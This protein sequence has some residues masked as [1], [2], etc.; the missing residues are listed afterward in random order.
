MFANYHPASVYRTMLPQFHVGEIVDHKVS[1]FVKEHRSIRQELLRRGMFET[2]YAFY[3]M[4]FTRFVAHSPTHTSS[5]PV[6]EVLVAVFFFFFFVSLPEAVGVWYQLVVVASFFLLRDLCFSLAFGLGHVAAVPT[7]THTLP[8]PHPIHLHLTFSIDPWGGGD[9]YRCLAMFGTA[10]WL[11]IGGT[12]TEQRLCGAAVLAIY[13]Q[14]LAFIGH[15][16]G[17]NATSQTK[18]SDFNWGTVFATATGGI[19]VAWWKHN[20]NVHHVVCNSVEHDPDVQHQ[21]LFATSTKAFEPYTSSFY[22]VDF[23]IAADPIAQALVGVQHLLFFPVMML[24]RFFLYVRS[25]MHLVGHSGS[26]GRRSQQIVHMAAFTIGLTA[27]INTLPNW[28]E[29]LMYLFTSHAIAGVL[30]LQ[31]VLS[32][33]PMD[34][35]KGWVYQCSSYHLHFP[36]LPAQSLPFTSVFRLRAWCPRTRL[37]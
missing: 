35:Y 14:Q 37:A 22:N 20:H 34:M 18:A 27:L 8:F 9:R 5:I 12:S 16:I 25:W 10:M 6:P 33:F 31:I 4:Q 30:H 19:S 11:T 21:P 17:H 28:S 23:S 1:D 2:D 3:V 24:A 32:H 36:P 29:A 15:D 26:I 7:H 13:W